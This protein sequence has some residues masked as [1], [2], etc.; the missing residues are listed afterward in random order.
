M[1]RRLYFWWFLDTNEKRSLSMRQR[2]FYRSGLA[3]LASSAILLT[4]VVPALA[5][6]RKSKILAGFYEE[7]SIYYA[8]YNLANL[9]S[10]GSAAKL[11]HLI[12]AFGGVSANASD[13]ASSTCVIADAWADF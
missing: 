7:W 6:D 10:N 8:G 13:P 9:E 12:Y 4:C 2:S 3:L 5:Q 11:S 1:S